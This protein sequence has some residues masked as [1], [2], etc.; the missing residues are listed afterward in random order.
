[1]ADSSYDSFVEEAAPLPGARRV[2]RLTNGVGAA[3]S[4]ALILG[5]AVWGYRIAVRDARGV[6]V[7]MALE[8]PM[9]IAPVDPGGEQMAHQGLAVN[10]VAAV[11]EVA[12]PAT[13]LVLAPRPVELTGEDQAGFAP[14]PAWAVVPELTS[15]IPLPGQ[16]PDEPTS[17]TALEGDLAAIESEPEGAIG[18]A[19]A[20]AGTAMLS[21]AEVPADLFAPTTDQVVEVA[22]TEAVTQ[23]LTEALTEAVPAAL[24]AALPEALPAALALAETVL[25]EPA[26]Q[27]LSV[28]VAAVAQSPRPMPRP[29]PKG[30]DARVAA[31]RPAPAI[32]LEVVAIPS[33]TRLVQLGAYDDEAAAAAGWTRLQGA[34]AAYFDGKSPVIQ[35]AEAGGKVF[36]RLRAL[37]FADEAEA[38][39]FCAVLANEQAQCIPVLT[40]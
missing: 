10:N 21:L 5:L 22:L 24:P 13:R 26:A 3:L 29:A 19:D 18:V 28:G 40:R 37:G 12:A 34:F 6:P 4:V 38:R 7:V 32:A 1:M 14:I 35:R 17:S 2:K 23:A 8:G 39:R 11:G 31:D 33:H 36:Y 30:E 20:L 15:L 9:R 16:F 27:V 25:A